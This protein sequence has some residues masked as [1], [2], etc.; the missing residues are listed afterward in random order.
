MHSIQENNVVSCSTGRKLKFDR[1]SENEVY[2]T[3]SFVLSN[4]LLIFSYL[5]PQT[6]L[7]GSTKL[8]KIL[9]DSKKAVA[10]SD[11]KGRMQPLRDQLINTISH[12]H[13]ILESHV[14]VAICRSYWDRMGKVNYSVF[15][16]KSHSLILFYLQVLALLQEYYLFIYSVKPLL[17]DKGF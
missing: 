13:T 4:I 10:D 15:V 5:L 1:P 12:L 7:Q 6:R 2:S 11:V 9:L 16:R 17:L 8:K 3:I 14:F